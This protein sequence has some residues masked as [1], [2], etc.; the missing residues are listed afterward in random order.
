MVFVKIP[1]SADQGNFKMVSGNYFARSGNF[2]AI[3]GN[4]VKGSFSGSYRSNPV[5]IQNFIRVT[6]R[7]KC[8]TATRDARIA[9]SVPACAALGV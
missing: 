4:P 1:Y 2:F 3:T 8:V 6:K 7:D 5:S 9:D